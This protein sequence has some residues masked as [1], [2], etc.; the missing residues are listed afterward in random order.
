MLLLVLTPVVSLVWST[1]FDPDEIKDLVVAGYCVLSIYLGVAASLAARS[2]LA[3]DLALLMLVAGNVAGGAAVAQWLSSAPGDAARLEGIWGIDN[4][5]HGSV[6]LLAVTLPVLF[7]VLRGRRHP[8]WCAAM[9]IPVCF[10]LLAGARSAAVAYLLIVLV[11]TA[12]WRLKTAAWVLAGTLLLAVVATVLLGPGAIQEVWLSRGLSFRDLVWPQ[13]WS[14][15]RG[16]N[17]ALGCGIAT[18]L[19][20]DLDGVPSTRA[21][22][23]FLAALYHQGFLGLLVFITALCW[24]LWSG[25][26]S[27]AAHPSGSGWAWMLA[28]VLLA[29]VTSGDHVLVRASL[30]WPC[31]W[32]PAMVLAVTGRESSPRA[33]P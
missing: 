18:P 1:A 8:G 4:P 9:I 13:V 26:R 14:E 11:M 21:H 22:S 5:V 2:A 29:N 23:I 6:L 30:F 20:V 19:V 27:R 3:D 28:Y 32:L 7:N 16:C 25:V 15:Y 12:T 24:L 17:P 10:V 33:T 31:F